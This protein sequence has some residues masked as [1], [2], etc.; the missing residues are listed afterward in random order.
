MSFSAFYLQQSFFTKIALNKRQKNCPID[1][2]TVIT[3]LLEA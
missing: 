1:F 2:T 3:T